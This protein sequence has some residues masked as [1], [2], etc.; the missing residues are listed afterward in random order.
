M[1]QFCTLGHVCMILWNRIPTEHTQD[2]SLFQD[3]L[4]NQIPKIENGF[5]N[6]IDICD[7]I[8]L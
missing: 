3:V 7:V 5:K 2:Q 1:T 8:C 4:P 6:M